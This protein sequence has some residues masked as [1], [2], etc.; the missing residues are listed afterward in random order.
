MKKNI[1]LGLTVAGLSLATTNVLATSDDSQY[2]AANFQPKVVYVDKDIVKESTSKRK[3]VFDPK[4]PAANFQPQVVYIDNDAVKSTTV[5][6][7]KKA[8]IIFDPKYPAAYFEPKVIY[9]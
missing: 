5:A 7:R 3:V 9:P 2:P 4:Y 6:V 1:I 8:E